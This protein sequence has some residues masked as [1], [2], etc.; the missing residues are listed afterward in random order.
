MCPDLDLEN[1][2]II[3]TEVQFEAGL[4]ATYVCDDGYTISSSVDAARICQLNGEWTGEAPTCIG[5][6]IV[7]TFIDSFHVRHSIA[8]TVVMYHMTYEW[9]RSSKKTE[10]WIQ[11]KCIAVRKMTWQLSRQL[12]QVSIAAFTEDFCIA[13]WLWSLTS[14][15]VE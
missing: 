4:L 14:N 1:G 5:M 2:M 12:P 13:E 15:S 10:S 6:F 3:N 9:W 11:A 7:A 8:V